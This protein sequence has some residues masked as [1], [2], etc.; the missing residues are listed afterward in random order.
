MQMLNRIIRASGA[1]AI[2][3]AAMLCG[4]AQGSIITDSFSFNNLSTFGET[5][6]GTF[7]YNT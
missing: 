4:R 6:T 7:S 3:V 2:I 1:L 5:V